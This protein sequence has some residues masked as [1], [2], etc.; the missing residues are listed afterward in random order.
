M[1]T[2]FE[3]MTFDVWTGGFMGTCFRSTLGQRSY[4]GQSRGL[5]LG[6]DLRSD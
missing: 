1:G 3:E 5:M 4:C 6:L 2:F